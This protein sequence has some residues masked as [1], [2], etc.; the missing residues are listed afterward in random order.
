MR[1]TAKMHVVLLHHFL[2]QIVPQSVRTGFMLLYNDMPKPTG[3][4]CFYTQNVVCIWNELP[5]E[6]AEAGI[7]TFKRQ[8]EGTWMGII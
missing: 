6:V 2:T 3:L 5:E 7:T 4:G 8:L 1:V